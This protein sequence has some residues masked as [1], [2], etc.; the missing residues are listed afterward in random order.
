MTDVLRARNRTSGDEDR[1]LCV[2]GFQPLIAM[3]EDRMAGARG[4]LPVGEL[5]GEATALA[6]RSGG[7]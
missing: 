7:Q 1:E 4:S 2:V 5:P 3:S 6:K